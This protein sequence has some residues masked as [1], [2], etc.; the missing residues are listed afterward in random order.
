MKK[1]ILLNLMLASLQIFAQYSTPGNYQSYHFDELVAIS[2]GAVTSSDGHFYFN[3]AITISATDTLII[4]L[5][6]QLFIHEGLLWTIEGILKC[7]IPNAFSISKVLGEGNFEGI[8]IDN[9]DETVLKKLI[10]SGCGG[11][12]LIESDIVIQNCDFSY[13]GQ[14]YSTGAIDIFQ[15]NPIIRD[16]SFSYCE[17]PAIA[18]GANSFSSPQIINNVLTS[19]VTSNSNTPQIN[20]GISNG[21]D[22]IVIDSNH[23]YGEYDM[24]GGIAVANFIGASMSAQITHNEITDNRYGIAVLGGNNSGFISYNILV[25][26]NIQN[27]PMLGGSGINL[28]GE[29]STNYILHHNIIVD[30]LW[31]ITIQGNAQ[32]NLG[33]GSE[34]SPGHNQLYNNGNNGIIYALYNNTP[35]AIM[36]MDNFWGTATLEETE[37]VIFHKVDDLSLGQVFFDPIWTPVGITEMQEEIS[38]YPNPAKDFIVWQGSTT[39]LK[40]LDISGKVVWEGR[41]EQAEK[42][43]VDEWKS[44]VYFLKADNQVLKL[45]VR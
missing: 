29:L 45:M 35:V 8:R 23:V 2:N 20:L 9:S 16:C 18:S 43:K 17:G 14:E 36:A 32:P 22:P 39:D 44:G 10:I 34:D 1:F 3:E 41:V 7:E 30:H 42:I 25:G 15:S 26:N 28:N 40:V 5:D 37:E 11:M 33:D 12:K 6:A 27:D 21:I 19:N 38:I 24:A 13:F 4:D 31:G